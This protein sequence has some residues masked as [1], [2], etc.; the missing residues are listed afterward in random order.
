MISISKIVTLE[1]LNKLSHD[2]SI[3]KIEINP[4]KCNGLSN[5]RIRYYLTQNNTD[6]FSLKACLKSHSL[7][8][9]L[10]NK[11]REK[12]GGYYGEF[13]GNRLWLKETSLKELLKFEKE[14]KINF[15]INKKYINYAVK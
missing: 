13:V 4:R 11:I 7:N 14:Y 8:P 9:K 6:S 15:G 5:I 12:I 1:E 2:S 3:S 10:P